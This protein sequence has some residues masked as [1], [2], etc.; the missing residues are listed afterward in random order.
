M[1]PTDAVPS[2]ESATSLCSLPVLHGAVTGAT[3]DAVIDITVTAHR[4]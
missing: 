1:L 3:I 4:F 2:P